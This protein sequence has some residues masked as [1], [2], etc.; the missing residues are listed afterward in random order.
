MNEES[1]HERFKFIYNIQDPFVRDYE[2]VEDNKNKSRAI[3]KRY[4]S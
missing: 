3:Y 2:V 1:F 4:V